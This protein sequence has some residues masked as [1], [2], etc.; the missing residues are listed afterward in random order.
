MP[1]LI[2]VHG[3]GD[4]SEADLEKAARGIGAAFPDT[5]EENRFFVN[6]NEAAADRILDEGKF[7]WSS[8]ER[9]FEALRSAIRVGWTSERSDSRVAQ[10]M[11]SAQRLLLALSRL[12]FAGA[13]LAVL[14]IPALGVLSIGDSAFLPEASTLSSERA[15]LD[16]TTYWFV[17][18]SLIKGV[19]ASGLVVSLKIFGIVAALWLAA[20]V[21]ILVI[22][23]AECACHR[24]TAPIRVAIRRIFLGLAGPFLILLLLPTY[25]LRPTVGMIAV[26]LAAP[27][28]FM[29][30]VLG[31]TIA[32][33]LPF[34]LFKPSLL[35]PSLIVTA[36]LALGIL[37]G[38]GV[39]AVAAT[40]L[41]ARIRPGF[42]H[43]LK[44]LLDILLYAGD[45]R[46]R[47]DLHA[48][49]EKEIAAA[50]ER[51]SDGTFVIVAHSLGSV[52]ALDSLLTSPQWNEREVILLVTMGSPIW[53]FFPDHAF[54]GTPGEAAALIAR[55]IAQF[56]WINIYRPL[57]QIGTSLRFA[58][59]FEAID[60]S[61]GQW[62]L[63]LSAHVNY[64]TDKTVISLLKA[65]QASAGR[66]P[67]ARDSFRTPAPKLSD[68]GTAMPGTPGTSSRVAA[69]GGLFPLAFV[70]V[71]I[72]MLI[73]LWSAAGRVD[74]KLVEVQESFAPRGDQLSSIIAS[75]RRIGESEFV[76]GKLVPLGVGRTEI[77][78]TPEG[79]DEVIVEPRTIGYFYRRSVFD[80]DGA[81]KRVEAVCGREILP[82]LHPKACPPMGIEV[83]YE[84]TAPPRLT[85]PA[86]QDGPALSILGKIWKGLILVLAAVIACV[87]IFLNIW[88]A[89]RA[90]RIGAG[91]S[92]SKE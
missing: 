74:Q 64:W 66:V 59:D 6:W 16:P 86:F 58:K 23:A 72:W 44:V 73:S 11:D 2:V 78:F 28:A 87:L 26:V 37:V 90:A 57:D 33:I 9:M 88:T 60:R 76:E 24:S 41:L 42:G 10:L 45:S 46:F 19:L 35:E 13:I 47:K 34:V 49:F 67:A 7:R 65:A 63:V 5:P 55:R 31:I 61:T 22:A 83:L 92:L 77:F 15:L 48:A 27:L 70:S 89:L 91:V 81:I 43:V 8:V 38:I 69:A 71:F 53:R 39:C 4:P 68:A 52:M 36:A 32:I 40:Y 20:V 25:D 21:C 56:R 1:S 82:A 51:T 12:C 62:N 18:A 50:R 17:P 85:L 80:Y 79:G 75:A 84:R 3:V 54:P 29:A 14:L 30:Y